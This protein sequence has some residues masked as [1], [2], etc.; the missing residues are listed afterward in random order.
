MA[1]F[2]ILLSF[3]CEESP[4]HL[5]RVGKQDQARRAL[6]KIWGLPDEHHEISTEMDG[7]QAQLD[8]E[9][10]NSLYRVW[11]NSLKTLFL[12]R[13]NIKRLLYLISAQILSQWSGANSLTS[14]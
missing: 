12:S 1:G 2:L 9:E 10:G 7:I 13:S 4:R 5:C 3:F 6:A 11:V 8:N 14:I